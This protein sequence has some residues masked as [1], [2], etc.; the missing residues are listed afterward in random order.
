M[1]SQ[2]QTAP[3][4]WTEDDLE[5][6]PEDGFLH[7]VVDGQL[8]MSPKND[9]FH[10]RI[11]L[12]LASALEHYAIEHRLG[13][14]LDSSTGFWMA[15]RNCR[16]PDVS[17]VTRERLV[18]LGFDPSARKF[19]PEAPDLAV[20]VLA[21]ANSRQEMDARLRDFFDSGTRLVWIIQP[22][23]QSAEICRSITHRQLVGPGG[24]L[25][26][27]DLLPGF[28]YPLVNLFKAWDWE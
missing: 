3:R 28:R 6:L 9:F 14:V 12:R 4:T 10:G 27:G 15:N 8:V 11:C 17:F 5:S 20:E 1:L 24:F 21:P 7:E 26:G 22:E 23:P 2:I 18:A 16:A 19:F 25:D 13:L